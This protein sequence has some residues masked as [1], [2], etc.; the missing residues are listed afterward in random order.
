MTGAAVGL[1]VYS[2]FWSNTTQKTIAAPEVEKEFEAPPPP[3]VGLPFLSSPLRC[4]FVCVCAFFRVPSI[5]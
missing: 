4:L 3:Y 1:A 2:I 5:L